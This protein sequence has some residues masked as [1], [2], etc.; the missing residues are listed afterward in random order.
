MDI[1]CNV[2]HLKACEAKLR[3]LVNHGCKLYELAEYPEILSYHEEQLITMIDRLKSLVK[4]TMSIPLLQ[5]VKPSNSRSVA[6]AGIRIYLKRGKGEVNRLGVIA[7]VLCC[8]SDE[9]LDIW[10]K[11]PRLG[12]QKL[13]TKFI[14]KVKCLLHYGALLDDIKANTHLLNNRSLEVIESRAKKLSALGFDKPLQTG[15]IG[16]DDHNFEAIVKRLKDDPQTVH[17]QR[18][19]DIIRMLPNHGGRSFQ[20]VHTFKPKVDLLLE[21]GYTPAE[22]QAN[23]TLLMM[24][25]RRISAALRYL[26]E[27]HLGIVNLTRCSQY[28]THNTLASRNRRPSMKKLVARVLNCSADDMPNL[29]KN[30]ELLTNDI[31]IIQK[32]VTFLIEIGFTIDDI[33]R[34]PL[35]LAHD[36]CSL[37]LHWDRLMCHETLSEYLQHWKD[38]DVKRLNLLQYFIEKESNFRH[39][40][41]ISDSNWILLQSGES[42]SEEQDVQVEAS[43]S[44]MIAMDDSSRHG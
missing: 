17:H 16:R 38:D 30:S 18:S 27:Y 41:A 10:T 24:S 43:V 2:D 8:S 5:F 1:S 35:L 4:S 3:L 33:R 29:P 26:Q 23:P 32:N 25:L 12:G 36:P 44:D 13:Q 28:A 14:D 6:K 22:I 20:S 31:A 39:V 19:M 7:D 34:M 21:S 37:R 40:S 42:L 15:V 9:M 11:N